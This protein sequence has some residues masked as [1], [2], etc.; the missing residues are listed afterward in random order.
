MSNVAP[1]LLTLVLSSSALLAAVP[2]PDKLLP[3]DTLGVLTVPNWAATQKA[4]APALRLW[5]DSAMKPFKDKFIKKWKSDFVEPFQREFG[6]KFDD[7]TGLAQ[8]QVTWA[9]TQTGSDEK[10]TG[11]LFLMD[12]GDK[13]D[14]MKTNLANLKKGWVRS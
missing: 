11:L 9:I 7:Y 10:S 13:A 14:A 12:S 4:S 3:S 5:N 1:I 6:I 2:A 8:G